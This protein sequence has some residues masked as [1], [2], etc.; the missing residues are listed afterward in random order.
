MY[1]NGTVPRMLG[2][3]GGGASFGGRGGG[4][5]HIE[6]VDMLQMAGGSID[7]SGQGGLTTTPQS[8]E[9]PG[10]GGAGGSIVMILGRMEGIARSRIGAAGGQGARGND[11][12]GAGAGG[13][14]VVAM[15]FR[16]RAGRDATHFDS[17]AGSVD[18]E[19]RRSTAPQS[20][21]RSNTTTCTSTGWPGWLG[22]TGHTGRRWAYHG[23][24]CLR[25]WHLPGLLR[26][27]PA[28][29]L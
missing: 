15:I 16:S 26:A 14:G 3:G 7:V 21:T 12:A 10:G 20:H 5:I 24:T 22:G 25:P 1:D 23:I 19:V 13:G 9:G 28:G 4:L 18:I 11:G 17:G 2:S 6:V 27:V 29:V 8:A